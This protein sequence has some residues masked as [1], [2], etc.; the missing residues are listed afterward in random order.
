MVLYATP[1]GLWVGSDGTK[2]GREDH[3]GIGFAPLDPGPTPDTT[4]PN[5][6]IDSGPSGSVTD[7]SATFSFSA[8]EPSTFQCRLDGAAFAP[9]TSPTSYANLTAGSH[10]FQVA[11]TDG[12]FNVDAS[13][14]ERT[15]TV[16]AAAS[17]LVGNPGFEVD[18]SGWKGDAAANTLSRVA[19]GHS[20]GWAAEVSNTVAGGNCGLDDKPSWVSFTQAGPY[21][22]S[23]WARSDTPGLTLKLRVREYVSGVLQGSVVHV[24]GADLVVATGDG[25]LHAGRAGMSSLDFEAFTSQLARRRVLPGR[26]R[27]HHPLS[28]EPLPPPGAGS[29]LGRTGRRTWSRRRRV[30]GMTLPQVPSVD[31]AH[32]NALVE[33]RRPRRVLR[34][35]ADQ[36]PPEPPT[37]ERRE[38]AAEK[39]RRD[40]AAPVGRKDAEVVHPAAVARDARGEGPD[41]LARLPTPAAR[42]SGHSSGSLVSSSTHVSNGPGRWKPQSSANASTKTAWIAARSRLGSI[43]PISM[44]SGEPPGSAPRSRVDLHVPE[45]ADRSQAAGLED[46]GRRVVSGVDRV[47][48]SR[49]RTPGQHLSGPPL[50]PIEE[51]GSEAP[52]SVRRMHDP[53]GLHHVR[54]VAH[55]VSVGDDRTCLVD[56][57]PGIGGEVETGAAPPVPQEVCVQDDLACAVEVLG[58]QHVG[59][60]A[61]VVMERG[62]EPV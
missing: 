51:R 61:E 54:P 30:R 28:R 34:I 39:G 21:T 62:S 60:G 8:N 13:P 14:A 53:Q 25:G 45:V 1:Q 42:A 32:P 41:R 50:D 37:R 19:G 4:R 31:D 6:F 59:H 12:S 20:G 27:I 48:E 3:A 46:R 33:R 44:P 29:G 52:A 35:D 22:V 10:T 57:D 24:D 23:I 36:R 2:F 5:T 15:W 43:P 47:T 18:T 49:V 26:R 7:T 9:C 58:D 40:P 11:A 16:V 38:R 56:D 55:G 17:N